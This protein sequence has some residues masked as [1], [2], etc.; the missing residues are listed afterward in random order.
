LTTQSDAVHE[1]QVYGGVVVYERLQIILV[2]L[3]LRSYSEVNAMK[4]P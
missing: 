2:R 4:N 1:E 3:G